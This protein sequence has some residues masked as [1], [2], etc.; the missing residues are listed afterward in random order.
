MPA[1]D[2]S[3]RFV[4]F[5]NRDGAFALPL[6]DVLAVV[7]LPK[8]RFLPLLPPQVAGMVVHDG[9][10]LPL[11]RLGAKGSPVTA[12]AFAV[13]CA[14]SWGRVAL[15]ADAVPRV[16]AP[17]RFASSGLLAA[18]EN[19]ERQVLYDRVPYLLLDI[20]RI[21]AELSRWDFRQPS[22]SGNQEV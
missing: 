22:P 11:L 18:G 9:E 12:S 2:L 13:I 4:L 14:V 8:V 6:A 5:R 7:P 17:E 15:S 21:V 16:P 3:H 10:A 20:E 1:R 19:A